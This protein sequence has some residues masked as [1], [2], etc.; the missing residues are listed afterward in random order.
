MV[1]FR[2]LKVCI[3]MPLRCKLPQQ[4]SNLEGKFQRH[5]Y[6]KL[7][8]SL[9][10]IFSF[11]AYIHFHLPFSSRIYLIIQLKKQTTKKQNK[12]NCFYHEKG[13]EI[14]SCILLCPK[15][16]DGFRNQRS[17]WCLCKNNSQAPNYLYFC[18]S[19]RLNTLWS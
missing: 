9:F 17:T 13:I 1:L 19:Q 2:P 18:L 8:P 3:L 16:T 6:P 4:K 5:Q 12:Q 14:P 11:S 7:A 10:F 15:Y